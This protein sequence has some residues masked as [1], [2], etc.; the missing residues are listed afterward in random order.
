MVMAELVFGTV[1]L[2]MAY[3]L[4][5]PGAHK[6]AMPSDAEAEALVER[7]LELGVTTFDTAPA[8]GESEARL[9]RI[10]GER[11]RVWT[12]VSGGAFEDS[13]AASF[14]KLRRPRIELLQWHNWTAALGGDAAWRSR[15]SALRK[16]DRILQLGATTYGVTDAVAAATCGLFDV[17]QC[18]FNVLNQQVVNALAPHAARGEIAI[19]LRSV[20]LQGALTDEGRELPARPALIDGVARARAVAGAAGLTR[21]ALRAALERTEVSYVLVGIDRASQLDEAVRIAGGP[22]L[23]DEQA[24]A[25]ASLDLAGDPACDPRA[26]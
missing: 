2:G 12:K 4:P 23:S 19:A 26:W 7:A 6:N 18:E 22:P 21:F 16:D 10:L 13:I 9:G 11:A 14:A 25:I 8:Y 1:A 17:V 24:A 5:R 20:F 15:W 3:G